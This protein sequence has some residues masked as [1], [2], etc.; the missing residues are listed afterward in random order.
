MTKTHRA[1]IP[2]TPDTWNDTQRELHTA[3][4]LEIAFHHASC[5][6]GG[7]YGRPVTIDGRVTDSNNEEYQMRPADA[8]LADGWRAIYTIEAH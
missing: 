8:T 7:W 4:T 2:Y 1:H 6:A 3:G 5:L